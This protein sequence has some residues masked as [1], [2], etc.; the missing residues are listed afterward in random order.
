[1]AI[2]F[3]TYIQIISWHIYNLIWFYYNVMI[4]FIIMIIFRVQTQYIHRGYEHTF[5]F[6]RWYYAAFTVPAFGINL[7]IWQFEMKWWLQLFVYFLFCFYFY[8]LFGVSMF[9]WTS[10]SHSIYCKFSSKV[11]MFRESMI[12]RPC[13]DISWLL[14]V[15]MDH[16]QI[17]LQNIV[18][19]Q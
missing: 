15:T 8:Y 19:R 16:V 6:P 2:I 7:Y 12:Q 5:R 11:E 18:L 1:M 14:Y 17:V 9:S 4:L 10:D 3:L 13:A